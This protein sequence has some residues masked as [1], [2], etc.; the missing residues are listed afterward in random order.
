MQR[1]NWF[2][3]CVFFLVAAF[4]C[5]SVGAYEINSFSDAALDG[6]SVIDFTGET[7]GSY[8]SYSIDD[9][10]FTALGGGGI[11][12]ISDA[13]GG[14]YNTVGRNLQNTGSDFLSLRVDFSGLT[15]AFAFNFGASDIVWSLT[16]FDSA[17]DPLEEIAISPVHSS[18]AGDVFGIA[19]TGIS[20]FV[21]A[22]PGSDYILFDNLYYFALPSGPSFTLS[23]NTP[24]QGVILAHLDNEIDSSS[25][26]FL[27]DLTTLAGLPD[28][29]FQRALDALSP[30]PYIGLR[31][32]GLRIARSGSTSV[33][34]RLQTLRLAQ[35]AGIDPDQLYAASNAV[36][37]DA[38]MVVGSG[39]QGGF[40]IWLKPYIFVAD[41]DGEDSYFGYTHDSL[42]LS[43]GA[44]Y[45]LANGLIVGV[46]VGYADGTV[47]YGT[48]DAETEMASTYLGLY[49]SSV[50]GNFHL[51]GQA[52]WYMHQF[53]TNRDLDF[54]GRTA[55]SEHDADEL[56]ATL[57][58]EYLG[59]QPGGWNVVPGLAVTFS[60][61][62]EEGFEESGAGS[63]NLEGDHVNDET[64]SSRLGVRINRKF[65]LGGAA[66]I[67]EFKAAWAHD[68]HDADRDV[69]ARFAGSQGDAFTIE[70]V[71][72]DRDSLLV[73]V[74]ANFVGDAMSV[75][76]NY[77]SEI[78]SEYWSWGLSAGIRYD[79]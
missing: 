43:L 6:A 70:G 50:F 1:G 28:G 49:A 58:C 61:Y 66:F 44:D 17:G 71:E 74:G 9:V 24:N 14:D 79:F 5:G 27:A 33:T 11:L 21:L 15:N 45:T 23:A 29:D 19:A 38:P 4:S 35:L 8:S 67:P 46:L 73:G 12:R 10:D 18:N 68:F 22:Q 55:K 76:F 36:M 2:F 60:S 3:S 77:D 13:Y 78:S 16:A 54:I 20:Y 72:P 42:G 63:F 48:V 56:V 47:D 30:E 69:T 62:D 75:F 25:G 32:A 59:L 57:G 41:Q 7:L 53:D 26:S 65:D 40:G 51:H 34:E 31:D 37:S 39:R 64:L 52:A